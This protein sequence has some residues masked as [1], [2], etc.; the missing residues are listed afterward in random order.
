MSA[1]SSSHEHPHII[2]FSLLA[3]VSK[4]R[5]KQLDANGFFFKYNKD[6]INDEVLFTLLWHLRPPCDNPN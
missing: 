5:K 3:V 4:E 6:C 2:M 1:F